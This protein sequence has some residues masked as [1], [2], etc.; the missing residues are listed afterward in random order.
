MPL[1]IELGSKVAASHLGRDAY[2]YV[3]QS[4]LTQVREH[5]ES[6]EVLPGSVQLLGPGGGRGAGI[7]GGPHEDPAQRNRLALGGLGRRHGPAVLADAV[8]APGL[9]RLGLVAPGQVV[10]LCGVHGARRPQ[11]IGTDVGLGGGGDEGRPRTGHGGDVAVGDE[12]G[13]AHQ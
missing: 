12:H 11:R 1:N 4:T 2:V 5:T 3:R 13:V 8:A 10:D 9:G 6:L 7:G